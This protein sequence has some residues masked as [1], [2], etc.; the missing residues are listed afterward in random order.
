MPCDTSGERTVDTKHT[1]MYKLKISDSC[2]IVDLYMYYI[3]YKIHLRNIFVYNA[4]TVNDN[5]RAPA[6]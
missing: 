4:T 3:M 1:A 5:L 6:D 2:T